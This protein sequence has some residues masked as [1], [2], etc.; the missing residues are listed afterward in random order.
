[1][2]PSDCLASPGALF[3]GLRARP[4][5]SRYLH[6]HRATLRGS[7]P[8]RAVAYTAAALADLHRLWTD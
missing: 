2:D 5:C 6:E 4:R 7:S 3:H 8:A 1:M